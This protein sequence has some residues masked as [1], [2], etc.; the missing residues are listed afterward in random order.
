MTITRA[1]AESVLIRRCGKWL[2][3]AGLDGVTVNGT[4]N[5]L[6]DPL[7]YALRQMGINPANISSIA[8]S[9]LA[10]VDDID[11]LLDLAELRTLKNIQQNYDAVNL[12]VGG[13]SESYS[14]FANRIEAAIKR[15]QEEIESVYGLGLG[16]LEAGVIQLDFA[17]RS[18]LA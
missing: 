5:D 8:D 6:N 14:D 16:S 12:S 13:R 7:G 1:Q 18:E 2:T 15:K 9:D 4:N 10:G 11:R 3:M 17:Q